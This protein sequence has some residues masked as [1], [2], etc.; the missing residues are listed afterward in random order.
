MLRESR[1]FEVM[2]VSSFVFKNYCFISLV[3]VIFFMEILKNMIKNK[4]SCV[5]DIV[6]IGRIMYD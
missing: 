4:V 3:L 2:F 5:C 6:K 1:V